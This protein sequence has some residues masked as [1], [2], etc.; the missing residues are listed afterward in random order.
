MPTQRAETP[1]KTLETTQ[2]LQQITRKRLLF[3][4][5]TLRI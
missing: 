4:P 2:V 1:M 3:E 5:M